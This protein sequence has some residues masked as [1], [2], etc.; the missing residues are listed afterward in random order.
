MKGGIYLKAYDKFKALD[1][2]RLRTFNIML[3][4]KV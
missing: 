1:V 2:R 4:G 3:K